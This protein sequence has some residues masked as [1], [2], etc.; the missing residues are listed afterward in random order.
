MYDL[1]C[2]MYDVRNKIVKIR[3]LIKEKSLCIHAEAVREEKGAIKKIGFAPLFIC[4]KLWLKE[5]ISE[6]IEEEA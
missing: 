1:R 4:V 3:F 2:K 5:K 6:L